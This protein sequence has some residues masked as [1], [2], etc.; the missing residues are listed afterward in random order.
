MS[1][2]LVKKYLEAARR[3]AD[4][5]VLKPEGFAFAPH[6][7][8]ADTDRDK[9]CVRR[10][11]DFYRRQRTDY[12]DYFLA[13]W[14]FRHREALGRPAATLADFAAEAG[15][16]PK[17]LATIWSILTATAGGGRPDRR[18]SG[19]VA[20]APPPPPE[21]TEPEAVA[22]RLRADAGFRR[23]A[24]PA[25]HAGGQEPDRS[26][27]SATAPSRS[28]SG[29]IASTWRTGCATPAVRSSSGRSGWRPGRAA[30]QAMAVP[31]RS[32][33]RRSGTRR[34]SSR[35]CATF[36]DAFF[37][38]ERARVYLDPK[39]EK[40]NAGR[41]LSAGFHSMTGYF[42]DDGPLYELMLDEQGQ[43][44]LDGLWQEFD[45]IT[46]APMRQYTSFLWFE[47][48]DSPVHAGSRV[49]LRPRRGQGR[50]VRGQDQAAGRGLPGEGPQRIGASDVALEAIE[51]HFKIISASIRR[52]EQDA[53][54]GGTEP[55]R[56]P[57]GVRRA[58]LSP[59]AVDGGA[60]RRR[61][62]LSHAPRAGRAGPRGRRPRHGR[63]RADVA[64]LLLPGRPARGGDRRAAAVGL[65]PGQPPE[66]LPL[67][68]HARRGAAGPG[69]RRRPAPPR[70]PR[71]PRPGGCCATTASAAWPP[72]SAA[73]GSTS[74]GS[75]ST[76]A[77]TASGSRRFDDELRRSMFEE[78]IRF[79]IDLVRERPPG[80]RLPRRR[81]TRSSTRPSPATTACPTATA[82]P[83]TG[84]GST[85]R[86]ATAAAGCCRWRSS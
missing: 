13:A 82:G 57:P 77:S 3:V 21:G 36:P 76:T 84:C 62:V 86:R 29:R 55:R 22:G 68:E 28:C 26:R 60:R 49:R 71:R 46:G 7:V 78:P 47:R 2:A 23:R 70:G 5:V 50:G 32:G 19:D 44:E 80:P 45:F 25:A 75:R 41:L 17:Y 51:D 6:P 10:I 48:T 52:V 9:Y 81:T 16:S 20:R 4:H 66:L 65:R 38:S 58:G 83:T 18:A 24:P 56:G 14:R 43:R 53:A 79:F 8:V 27:N 40:E 11:I 34:P 15:L 33:R 73:T 72:S 1:P 42:R 67:V 59:S 63:R 69:R 30:A 39:K 74:A 61:R 64:P 37:V 54:R 85:T 35:F 12:A 31:D